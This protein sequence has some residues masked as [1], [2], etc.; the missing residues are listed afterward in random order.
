[1]YKDLREWL[2]QA[3]AIGELKV[4]KD[5]VDWNE[6]MTA[7]TYMVDK[8]QVE[9]A[10]ALLFENI[11]DHDKS[12][13]VLLNM[14]GPSP[15]RFAL[16]LGLPVNLTTPE[17]I[18]LARQR[19]DKRIPPKEIKQEDAP[20]NENVFLGD[21][22]DLTKLA[23]PKFWPLDGGR[24]LGTADAVITRDPEGNRINL[25]TYRLMVHNK[26]ELGFYVSPGKDARIHLEAAWKKGQPL[27]VAAV[28]GIDP[29]LMSV[30][31]WQY[32]KTV[33]EYEFM[34]GIKGEP[35]EVVK[36]L[37]TDLLIPAHGE[38]VVEGVIRP[39]YLKPEGGFGEFTGYYGRPETHTPVIEV[40]A[41]RY[42]NNPII[43]GALMAEY[44]ACEHAYM[45]SIIKSALIRND[46]A[47]MGI[48]GIKAVYS[49]PAAA[50]SYGINVVSMEQKYA[51][52]VSQVLSIV[53][54]AS[55]GSYYAK[56][57][58]AVEEDV[59][60]FDINQ[61]LWSMSTRCNPVEDI[62]ILRNTWSTYLDPTQNPPEERPYGS[63]A[64]INA[65]REHRYLDQFAKRTVLRKETYEKVADRWQELGLPGQPPKI[66]VFEK[67][68][69]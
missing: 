48:P 2:Q 64:L 68:V 37:V 66:S 16:A 69:K 62:D 18:E 34:G 59:D 20:I 11:K 21:D 29:L 4:I 52:H 46:L 42:R 25:G 10:P 27:E 5:E 50:A 56:W 26:N 65:C 22:I 1:M 55:A 36:G 35:I 39:G 3:D 14:L 58:V 19:I 43:T 38:M 8:A 32:D 15:N 6:E 61:V 60:I 53:A 24:Y 45:V 51:G 63:K 23:A 47:R 12:F 49:Y 30:A 41:L 17:Y 44:P 28:V 31:G 57:I 40:K 7:I 54:Q 67:D 9:K 13:R 33:S